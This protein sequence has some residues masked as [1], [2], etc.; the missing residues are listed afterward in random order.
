MCVCA[1]SNENRVSSKNSRVHVNTRD[2]DFDIQNTKMT[3][4][5]ETSQP[6][7]M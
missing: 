3:H 4:E 2:T 7:H 5:N 6:K 1:C